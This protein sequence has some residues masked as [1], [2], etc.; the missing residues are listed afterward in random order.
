MVE[1]IKNTKDRILEKMEKEI[2]ERGV[3]RIDVSE[4]GKL[5]D[6]VK[7]L[8]EAEKAC[9][10]AEY[11][12]SAVE[13]A[14][15]DGMGYDGQG[16]TGGNRSGRYGSMGYRQSGRGSANQYGRSG[17]SMGYQEHVDGLRTAMQNASPEERSRMREEARRL[18][19]M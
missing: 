14:G 9:W 19:E 18:L 4:M 8:A 7:D 1:V 3:D 17:Y 6:I 13:S 5:A 11:Y 12:R 15:Y 2:G 16:N 10:E